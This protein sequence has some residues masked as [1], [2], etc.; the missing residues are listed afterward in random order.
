MPSHVCQSNANF[1]IFLIIYQTMSREINKQS[2]PFFSR[3]QV[4]FFPS[5][6]V[7]IIGEKEIDDKLMA[8]LRSRPISKRRGK[9]ITFLRFFFKA[10]PSK[11][12]LL[13]HGILRERVFGCD[14]G[15]H[16]AHTGRDIPLILEMCSEVIEEYGITDGIYRL[17]GTVSNLQR[18]R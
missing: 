11:E 8:H 16:L 1:V 7:E 12:D 3:P 13:Q 4:G 9:F 18:L 17:S 5:H 2:S 6:C 14:L 10:R 15:E